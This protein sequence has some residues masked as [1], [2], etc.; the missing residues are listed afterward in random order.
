M[1][2]CKTSVTVHFTCHLPNG[3]KKLININYIYICIDDNIRSHYEFGN[4]M[5]SWLIL[6]VLNRFQENLR[7]LDTCLIAESSRPS[8]ISFMSQRTPGFDSV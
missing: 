4:I 8:A 1:L 2:H 5:E 7:I 6:L 3:Q